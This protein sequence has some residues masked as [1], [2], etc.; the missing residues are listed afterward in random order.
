[1][2]VNQTSHF[3]YKGYEEVWF[4]RDSFRLSTNGLNIFL[5]G[6]SLELFQIVFDKKAQGLTGGCSESWGVARWGAAFSHVRAPI[7][8]TSSSQ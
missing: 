5:C 8:N 3:M 7:I 1:M 6:N 4:E 2:K